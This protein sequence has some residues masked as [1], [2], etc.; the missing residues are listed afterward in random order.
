M[1]K[2]DTITIFANV[3]FLLFLMVTI[4]NCKMN[5]NGEPSQTETPGTWEIIPFGVTLGV[6]GDIRNDGTHRIYGL[7][8]HQLVEYFYN[9]GTWVTTDLNAS[10]IEIET[11]DLIIAKC[12][13]DGRNRL[14]A[15]GR[16]N[17]YGRKIYEIEFVNGNW[18]IQLVSDHPGTILELCK[19]DLQNE[20]IDSLYYYEGSEKSLVELSYRNGNWVET[21]IDTTSF[22][23][24]SLWEMCIGEGRDSGIDSIY[25]LTDRTELFECT[26]N[27]GIWERSRIDTLQ[28]LPENTVDPY[29]GVHIARIIDGQ[30]ALYAA[31]G[32]NMY[33]YYFENNQWRKTSVG[34]G[35]AGTTSLKSGIGR[36]DGIT[37][38]YCSACAGMWYEFWFNGD[39]DTWIKKEYS[40]PQHNAIFNMVV[41]EG[42]ND[43]IT[44]IYINQ[45]NL[46]DYEL[47]Y[48]R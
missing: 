42:R 39:T 3:L 26:C 18:N 1:K 33:E 9:N 43:G 32:S 48:N 31:D 2:F 14:Y 8:D 38:L 29:L 28:D 21:P 35:I 23:S 41:G 45:F 5:D 19:G 44:R 37:R 6:I 16:D 46:D 4:P 24:S 13:R 12:R 34:E 20:G 36:N 22:D 17:F 7:R 47:T 11:F 40:M 30:A 25:Y 27:N 10:G 15:R